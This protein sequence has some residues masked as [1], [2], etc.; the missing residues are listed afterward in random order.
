MSQIAIG[1]LCLFFLSPVYSLTAIQTCVQAALVSVPCLPSFFAPF[2]SFFSSHFHVAPFFSPLANHLGDCHSALTKE[3]LVFQASYS[4][5]SA[6]PTLSHFLS[7]STCSPLSPLPTLSR[8]LYPLDSLPC[9]LVFARS[10]SLQLPSLLHS[11]RRET[12][13]L[14]PFPV[15]LMSASLHFTCSLTG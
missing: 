10:L 6:F 12:V 13:R 4:L 15:V 11:F 5:L 14:S 2:H 3:R 7:F 8:P 1:I 9:S